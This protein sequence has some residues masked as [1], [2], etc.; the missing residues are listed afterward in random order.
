M[1]QGVAPD[2]MIGAKYVNDSPAAGVQRTRPLCLYPGLPRYK[3]S[4]DMN[5]AASFSCVDGPRGAY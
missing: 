5:D 4:G 2:V 1:E 3:G